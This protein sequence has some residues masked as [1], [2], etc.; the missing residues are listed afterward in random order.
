MNDEEKFDLEDG[1]ES[2]SFVKYLDITSITAIHN[3]IAKTLK[4]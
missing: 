1:V 2:Q 3:W 4:F